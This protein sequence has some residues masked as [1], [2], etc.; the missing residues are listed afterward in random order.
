MTVYG[1]VYVYKSLCLTVYNYFIGDQNNMFQ[2]SIYDAYKMLCDII[3]IEYD[4]LKFI[5]VNDFP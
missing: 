3:Q 4:K 2:I 5:Y 1:I